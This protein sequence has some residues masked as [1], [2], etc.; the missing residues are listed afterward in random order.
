[1]DVRGKCFKTVD[2]SNLEE[3][4]GINRTYDILFGEDAQEGDKYRVEFE[5]V[6]AES[7]EELEEEMEWLAQDVLL[8]SDA[9]YE[10]DVGYELVREKNETSAEV[11]YVVT[12]A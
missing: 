11:A 6:S 4:D 8:A 7:G 10:E 2:A 12:D 1:M 9:S 3:K 5:T